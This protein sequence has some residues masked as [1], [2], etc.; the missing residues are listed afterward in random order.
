MTE[1]ALVVDLMMV[2]IER[3]RPCPFQP[4]VNVSIDLVRRLSR[5]IWTGG[6]RPLLEVESLPDE[7]GFYQIV[8][9][10]Q[11]WRAAR[12]AGLAEVLVRILPPMPHLDRLRKQYEENQVRADLDPVEQA[13]AIRLF[14]V[15]ADSLAAEELLGQAGIAFRRLEEVAIESR[16]EFLEHLEYLRGLLI[17]KRVHMTRGGSEV[18][19]LSRWR[20]TEAALGISESARKARLAILRLPEELLDAVRGLPAEHAVQISRLSPGAAQTALVR[21]AASLTH[22]EVRDVVD[23]L[24]E[25]AHADPV[26][27]GPIRELDGVLAFDVQLMRSVDLC[28]QLARLLRNLSPRVSAEQRRA[29]AEILDDL[30]EA[31]MLFRA[32]VGS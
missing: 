19:P 11:R 8:C 24:L 32:A 7:P 18:R 10:E 4:R 29:V 28:R 9:G 3:I 12:E 25:D 30:G 27:G 13:H 20:D 1:A 14:K 2:P 22:R 23:G 6:H 5:S 15:I 16:T 21:R 17:D 31:A 26:A